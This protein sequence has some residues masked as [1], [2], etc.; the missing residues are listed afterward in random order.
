[1]KAMAKVTGKKPKNT[2]LSEV[3]EPDAE[4]FLNE[5]AAYSVLT[6]D[7]SQ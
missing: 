6:I 1:M 7:N 2:D 4:V 5:N 3:M